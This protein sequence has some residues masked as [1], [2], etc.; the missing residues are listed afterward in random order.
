MGKLL[1]KGVYTARKLL[2]SVLIFTLALS[3]S[4]V[5]SAAVVQ[6][7]SN[8][9]RINQIYEK[10]SRVLAEQKAGYLE[11]IERLG[12]ELE[13][14]GVKFLS[15]LEVQRK[16]ETSAKTSNVITPNVIIPPN[17]RNIIWSSYRSNWVKNGVTYEVQ[18]LTA[19][20]NGLSSA[21]FDTGGI[22][23]QNF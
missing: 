1:F 22:V 7:V 4:G 3:S 10:R 8:E 20:P 12:N 13:S 17:D 15:P 18:H 6:S 9:K 21:L 14:L 2:M 19:E 23:L 16:M 11:E 5:A